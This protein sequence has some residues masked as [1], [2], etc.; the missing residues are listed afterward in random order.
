MRIDMTDD[1]QNWLNWGKLVKHWI[2]GG[3][4]P[5]TVK[6]L[7]DQLIAHQV[8]ASVEGGDDREVEITSYPD[9]IEGPLLIMLPSRKMLEERLETVKPGPYPLRL[10]YSLAFGGANKVNLSAQEASD[11][12]TRRIGEYTVNECC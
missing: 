12:A 2:E 6:Q 8:N 4:R 11:F 5:D 1:N 7:N 9:D 3:D 10:F